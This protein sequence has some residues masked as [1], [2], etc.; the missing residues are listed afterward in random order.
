MVGFTGMLVEIVLN[1]AQ[2]NSTL[3]EENGVYA[4]DALAM[5]RD[6]DM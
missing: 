4:L 6:A 1:G 5:E 2:N 3:L